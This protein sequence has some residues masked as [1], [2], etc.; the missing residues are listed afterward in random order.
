MRHPAWQPAHPPGSPPAPVDRRFGAATL[1]HPEPSAQ[2]PTGADAP[3]HAPARRGRIGP[4]LVPAVSLLLVSAFLLG[5]WSAD[6]GEVVVWQVTRPIPVGTAVTVADLRRGAIAEPL[7][8][9]ALR[10]TTDPHG[11]VARV[12]IAA[13][14]LLTPDV[15]TRGPELP[16]RGEA[17]VGIALGPGAA[18]AD[19]LAAGDVVRVVRVPVSGEEAGVRAG[20]RVVLAAAPVWAAR[21]GK[22]GAITVT[23][24]VAT[25]DADL[26]AGLGARGAIALERIA[27]GAQAAAA[28]P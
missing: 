20:G 23:L 12:P 7:A 28:V 27:A 3:P 6:R 11:Q 21:A 26:I 17:L 18:P 19:G 16:G 5:R 4:M 24:R 25:P 14:A 8:Q 13:G 15:L 10:A 2:P 22:Q 1:G 9:G